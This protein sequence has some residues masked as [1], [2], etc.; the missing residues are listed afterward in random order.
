MPKKGT[1]V[2]VKN[3]NRQIKIPFVIYANFESLLANISKIHN[4]N[5]SYTDK[6]CL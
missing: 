4:R 5:E 2:E 6:Y 3:F 1:T